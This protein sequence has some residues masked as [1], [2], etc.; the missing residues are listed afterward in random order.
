MKPNSFMV[1]APIQY[2]HFYTA[3]HLSSRYGCS[4]DRSFLTDDV[5]E[6][7]GVDKQLINLRSNFK[8]TIALAFEDRFGNLT[9]MYDALR[10]LMDQC[11][12]RNIDRDRAF[13]GV[14]G[15]LRVSLYEYTT[16]GQTGPV[17]RHGLAVDRVCVSLADLEKRIAEL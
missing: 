3:D 4:V 8:P 1:N 16:Q 7:L 9:D 12:I 2:A 10:R 13:T 15:E 14:K 17:K 5:L 6:T 11:D